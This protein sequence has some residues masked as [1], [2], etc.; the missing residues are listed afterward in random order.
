MGKWMYHDNETK[1]D[2]CRKDDFDVEQEG[3]VT[4]SITSDKKYLVLW[5]AWANTV[6][7]FSSNCKKKVLQYTG[8]LG[9]GLVMTLLLQGQFQQAWHHLSCRIG[10]LS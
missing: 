3:L 8:K 9:Y 10:S 6:W 7:N 5:K 4:S 2:V 1:H